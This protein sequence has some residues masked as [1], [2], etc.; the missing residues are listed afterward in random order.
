MRSGCLKHSNIKFCKENF[1]TWSSD[2][3][4]TL[5]IVFRNNNFN[6]NTFSLNL[7]SQID[8]F[9]NRL[10]QWQHRKLSLI[11]KTT[12][13]NSF[14]FLKLI[15][16]LTV[17]KNPSEYHVKNKGKMFKFQWNKKPDQI[18]RTIITY[19]YELGGLK[20]LN[21]ENF[22]NFF[23]TNYNINNNFTESN[24]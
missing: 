10:K 16:T 8:A 9:C 14:A 18:K 19:K 7:Q 24:M 17:L 6:D 13:I 3:A 21:I 1:F 5:G 20:M 12:V 2:S 4:K 15:Y 22:L 11:G 23:K